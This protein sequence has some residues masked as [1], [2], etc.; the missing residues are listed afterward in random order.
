MRLP[1]VT[2][3]RKSDGKKI[4][5]NAWEYSTN[6]QKYLR[7][8]FKIR[9]EQLNVDTPAVVVENAAKEDRIEQKRRRSPNSPAFDDPRREYEFKNQSPPEVSTE[10][11]PEVDRDETAKRTVN[12]ARKTTG[13]KVSDDNE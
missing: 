8:G 12:R 1:T 2:L 4:K 3:T 7:K 5:V 9:H 11:K 13:R 10:S 6:M